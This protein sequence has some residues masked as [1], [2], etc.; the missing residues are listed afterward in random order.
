MLADEKLTEITREKNPKKIWVQGPHAFIKAATVHQEGS[1]HPFYI[2]GIFGSVFH[3]GY[4]LGIVT[5]N[6]VVR[7]ILFPGKKSRAHNSG[8]GVFDKNSLWGELNIQK[9]QLCVKG[10]SEQGQC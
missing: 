2:D 9:G 1:F 5:K 8:A 6:G 10:I 3:G 4:P 7:F